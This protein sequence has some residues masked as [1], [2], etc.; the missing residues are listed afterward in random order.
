[1]FE[2][3]QNE[4]DR[5]GREKI[6]IKSNEFVLRSEKFEKSIGNAISVI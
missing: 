3:N 5:S 4:L 6:K 2:R 1:M